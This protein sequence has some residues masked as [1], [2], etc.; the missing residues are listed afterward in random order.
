MLPSYHI[1]YSGDAVYFA[2]RSLVVAMAQIGPSSR[3]CQGGGD[4]KI[5]VSLTAALVA[6][7][8]FAADIPLKAPA[9]PAPMYSWA[10]SYLGLNAGYGWSRFKVKDPT[11]FDHTGVVFHYDDFSFNGSGW[12]F[13]LQNGYNWQSGAWVFGFE[14]DLQLARINGDKN[15]H[16]SI[17]GNTTNNSRTFDTDVSSDINWFGTVRARLGYSVTPAML[18]YATGGFA[19]GEVRS[20]LFFPLATGG[21]TNFVAVDTH[22]RFGY[23]AGGGIE[24]KIAPNVS[25]KA[26]YL[27]VNLGNHS[28]S[29]LIANDVYTWRERVDLHTARIGVNVQYQGLIDTVFRR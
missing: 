23:S 8:A 29:F 15:F 10:G 1:I 28:N 25:L 11:E 16:A 22:T 5:L 20:Q 2:S 14:S 12:F 6:S 21:F 26:E 4:M 19:Y 18:I 24:H 7:P 3:Q 17:F 9:E 27:Y 13:G